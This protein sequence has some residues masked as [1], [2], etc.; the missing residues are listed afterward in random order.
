MQMTWTIESRLDHLF[1]QAR[2]QWHIPSI[3]RM[4]DEIARACLQTGCDRVLC[5]ASFLQGPRSE[6]DKYLAGTAVAERLKGARFAVVAR[7]GPS[8]FNQFAMKVAN[9]RGAAMLSTADIDEA[10]RW[11][12]REN[13]VDSTEYPPD[14][15]HSS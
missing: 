14:R 8:D 15:R 1:V 2:G 10:R 3:L 6:H 7:Q 9:Q 5:D 13:D 4:I 12:L 11:L